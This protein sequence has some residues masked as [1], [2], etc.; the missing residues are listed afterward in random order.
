MDFLK[1]KLHVQKQFEKMKD[2]KLFITDVDK[3]KMWETYLDSF[4]SGT[5]DI[6]RERRYYDCQCCRQF[7][8]AI[9]NVVCVKNNK[10]VSIWDIDKK[11]LDEK[12][13]VVAKALSELVKGKV[14]SNIFL[15]EEK[16]IG[17]DKN[18]QILENGETITWQ[19]FFLEIPDNFVKRDPGSI[20]SEARS[21]KQVF[22]RSLEEIT[23]D[24]AETVLELIEQNSIYRGE[25]HKGIIE[26]FIK[27]KNIYDFL[28]N[29][30]KDNYCW[31]KSQEV[32]GASKIR[33][34]AIGTLLVDIS[35]GI[36][37]DEAVG[38]FESKVAPTNYKRS[39]SVVTKKMIENAQKSVEELGIEDSLYRRY[40]NIKDITINNILFA[41]RDA[42]KNMSIFD[43]MKNDAQEKVKNL[44]KIE[45]VSIEKFI[46]DILPKAKSLE[47]MLENHHENNFV[48]LISP[49]Y[50]DSKNIFK[51]DNNFSWSY[52]GEVA[53]SMK[54]RVKSMGG[55]VD[56]V[57]RFSIQWNENNDNRNDFDA[58]CYEPNGFL[59]YY[60]EKR[61]FSTGGNLDV[62]IVNPGNKV[63]VENITWPDINKMQNGRYK[64]LVHNF[65]HNGGKSGFK[66]EIEYN[67]E[68]Y[69]YVYDKELRHKEKVTVAEIEFNKVTGIK[70]ISSLKNTKESKDIWGIKTNKFQNVSVVMN[71][72]N[73]WDGNETGNKH[74]FFILENCINDTSV[75]GFYNE[76]LR[77]EFMKHRKV[78][79][80]LASK[81]KVEKSNEQLSGVGFSS[82]QR[83]SVVC[84]VKGSFNSIVKIIF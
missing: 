5:N 6:F 49:Q 30:E 43:E 34:T 75:R 69:S 60:G 64:F 31:K 77:E 57:L 61:D 13:I 19:H 44:D 76:F 47:L 24:S 3:D 21:N 9:G 28:K 35:D 48:S 74:W 79:E 17:T 66:A 71:S 32:G 10:L 50:P 58:H 82:T 45:E 1:F 37:L 8:R 16:R 36:G 62:D 15:N 42:K 38:K 41:N 84:R 73:H 54:D 2:D 20:L 25:E 22:K 29:K 14:I 67:G 46:N 53:D 7:I 55:K 33:N 12:F 18:V 65:S 27:E 78:F 80:T 40:S 4:P 56:G 81:M 68:I 26:F 39:S 11:G 51:W 23:L 59:I 83:N 63:A 70:F 72:P 52:K